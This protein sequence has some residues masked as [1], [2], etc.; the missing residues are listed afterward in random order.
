M[1]VVSLREISI[2][3]TGTILLDK[4]SMQIEP[5]ERVCLLGRNGEGKS[6]L[7]RIGAPV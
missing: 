7:M 6:S 3:F 4:I 5:G 2:N 1:A